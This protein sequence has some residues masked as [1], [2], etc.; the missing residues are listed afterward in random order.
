M[1][2]YNK[3]AN[4]VWRP[5]SLE[6]NSFEKVSPGIKPHFLIQKIAQNDPEKKIPS[7]D[8]NAI[9]RSANELESLIHFKAH[10]AFFFITGTFSIAFK[11]KFFSSL[12]LM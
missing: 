5:S 7:T 10:S 6:M 12:S 11:R 2:L 3:H 4:S 1:Y 9:K 8:A